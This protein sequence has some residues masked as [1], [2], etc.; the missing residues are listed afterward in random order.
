MKKLK[1]NEK[2]KVNKKMSFRE[3]IEEHPE[4]IEILLQ[5][6]MHCFGCPMAQM[7]TLEEG[8]MAHGL[9]PD[10]IVMKINKEIMKNSKEKKR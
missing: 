6:G 4:S 2:N 1:E 9:N 5:S 7:E 8:A 10:E 3:I